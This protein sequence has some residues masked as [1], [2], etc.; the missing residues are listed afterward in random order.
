MEAFPS[1]VI[2]FFNGFKQSV[3]PLFQRPYEWKIRHWETLWNDVL[4]RY[5]AS[6]Q[7]S[8]FMGAIVTTPSRSVPVGVAKHLIIDGQQRLT[9]VALLLCSIRDELPS[10]A[11]V[12][13]SRIQSFYLTNQGYG[14]WDY[15][16]LLPTQDDR[17]G[18]KA[19][20]NT[21]ENPA[22]SE[23]EKAYSFFRQQIK[24]SD[25]DGNPIDVRRLLETIEHKLVIVNINLAE[26]EDPY[27]IFESLNAKGGRANP[28]ADSAR[29][30]F[31][32]K[33]PVE[34]QSAVYTDFWLPMQRRLGDNL[35]EFM[36]HYLM[37]DGEEVLKDDVY[38]QFEAA[39]TRS[40]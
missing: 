29:N 22:H 18:F 38:S 3:I 36:R 17:N 13:R 34:A 5:E 27:L 39:S 9:T 14:G 26:T 1:Q 32:M 8:Y 4:E 20:V 31:L 40:R 23:M 35:T 10:D 30:Y 7:A 21:L 16:K 24:G 15:F 37:R 19:L 25:S 28:E 11:E 33:F 6:T 2:Q 12:E